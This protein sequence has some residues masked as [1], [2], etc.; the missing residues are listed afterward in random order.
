MR[1]RRE[2]EAI[3]F[4][5]FGTDKTGSKIWE[6]EHLPRAIMRARREKGDSSLDLRHGQDRKQDGEKGEYA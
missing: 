6:N 1:A 5:T 4:Y 2:R 3:Q